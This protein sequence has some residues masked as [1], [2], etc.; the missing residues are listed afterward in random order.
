MSGMIVRSAK[1]EVV[2]MDL[3][4][5]KQ[6]LA[7]SPAPTEVAAREDFIEKKLSRR[8]RLAE[9]QLAEIAS[10]G[11]EAV[12]NRPN[13]QEPQQPVQQPISHPEKKSSRAGLKKQLPPL[14]EPAEFGDNE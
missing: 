10:A 4:K 3:L 9:M 5:I 7:S 11:P 8:K 14:E 1:G 6:S 12:A 2:D 13:I